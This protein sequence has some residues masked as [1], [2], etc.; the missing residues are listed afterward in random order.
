MTETVTDMP[1]SVEIGDHSYNLVRINQARSWNRQYIDKPPF[2]DGSPPLISSAVLTWHLGGFKSRTGIPGSSEY[3][4]NTDARLPFRLRPSPKLNSIILPNSEANPTAIAEAGKYIWF[5]CGR[6]VFRVDPANNN[7][8]LKKD[9]DA[10]VT[11]IDLER[12]EQDKLIVTT[13]EDTNSVY[14]VES[15]YELHN[16]TQQSSGSYYPYRTAAGINRLFAVSKSGELKNLSTGLNPLHGDSYADSVQIGR[17]DNTPTGIV[18]YDS[19]VVIAKPEGLFVV[20]IDGFG[21]PVIERIVYDLKNGIGLN[22]REPW[23]LYPHK[24]G[25]FRY[26]PGNAE[27]AGIERELMD[28]S[29]LVER[30]FRAFAADGQW[31]YGVMVDPVETDTYILV[32]RDRQ[33]NEPGWGPYVWDTHLYFDEP[34]ETAWVSGLGGNRL[35]VGHGNNCAYFKLKGEYIRSARRF[36]PKDRYDLWQSKD[37]PS[38]RAKGS[39]LENSR[40]WQAFYSVDGA[41]FLGVDKDNVAMKFTDDNVKQYTLPTSANGREIQWRFDYTSTSDTQSGEL[42]MF[43]GYAEPRDTEMIPV[44]SMTLRL[45]SGSHVDI[46]IDE[47][48]STDQLNDLLAERRKVKAIETKGPWSDADVAISAHVIDLKLVESL[49]VGN[50]PPDLLVELTLQERGV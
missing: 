19:S 23:I 42:N 9:L 46:Q 21:I 22:V 7:S 20:Q 8:V 39:N 24:R 38:I 27:R 47:R 13:D 33:E 11:V 28:E 5:A 44:I 17:T 16:W 49:Q 2:T 48:T 26:I 18:A 29:P 3:G 32:G 14:V 30:E 6:R 34:C 1:S 25:L 4:Q 37:F 15:P 35:W 43:E 12:W 50:G 31:L 40:Y 36:M 41:N 10:G 45:A